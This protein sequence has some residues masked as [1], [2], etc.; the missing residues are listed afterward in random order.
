MI[1][2]VLALSFAFLSF[3]IIY[4]LLNKV[5]LF[6]KSVDI[7]ISLVVSFFV[8]LAF[9]SY[10]YFILNFFSFLILLLFSIFILLSL[11]FYKRK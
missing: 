5:K 2:T 8:L 3:L 9:Y 11:Y 6:E 1:E 7:V 4:G 10:N